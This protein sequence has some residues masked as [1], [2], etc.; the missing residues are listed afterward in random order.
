M[1]TQV[2]NG[3]DLLTLRAETTQSLATATSVS[4]QYKKPSA[5]TGE[6]TGTVSGTQIVYDVQFGDI[7]ESGVW[8]FQSKVITPAG[9]GYGAITKVKFLN[10]L[11]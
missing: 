1:A 4:I 9:T 7:D 11:Q 5:I 8:T 6:F 3:Q 10:T 2:F